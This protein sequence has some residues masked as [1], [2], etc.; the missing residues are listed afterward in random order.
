MIAAMVGKLSPYF[1]TP[2][3]ILGLMTREPEVI[4][5]VKSSMTELLQA[6]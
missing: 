3:G 5:I 2:Q 1:S 4:D 6:I